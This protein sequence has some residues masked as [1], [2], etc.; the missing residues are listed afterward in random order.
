M[1]QDIIVIKGECPAGKYSSAS[2]SDCSICPVGNYCP[3]VSDKI[4]CSTNKYQPNEGKDTCLACG[5]GSY[6]TSDKQGISALA[7]DQK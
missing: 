1:K 3:G 4:L 7:M 2:S 5:A 6:V